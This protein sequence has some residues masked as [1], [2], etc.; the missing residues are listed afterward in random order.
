MDIG[1]GVKWSLSQNHPATGLFHAESLPEHFA[2]NFIK[3]GLK[4]KIAATFSEGRGRPVYAD[5]N[6]VPNPNL[7]IY[8]TIFVQFEWFLCQ[9]LCFLG[10]GIQWQCWIFDW[11]T[12]SL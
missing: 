3:I 8:L 4:K 7:G 5:E 2:T 6:P 11:R 1:V 10:Q 12:N 9:I